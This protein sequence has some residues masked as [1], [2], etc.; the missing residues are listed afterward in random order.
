MKRIALLLLIVT[1]LSGCSNY[2][3]KTFGGTVTVN[4][5]NGTKIINAT[6]EDDHLWYLTREMKAGE[7]PET[8]VMY[9][10]SAYGVLQGKIDF[11]ES[12]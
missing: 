4:L 6:W 2:F 7:Q 8:T 1:L 3:A 9:E 10:S 5:P 11:K 12:K